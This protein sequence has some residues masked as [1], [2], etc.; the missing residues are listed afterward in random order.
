MSYNLK[1][2]IKMFEGL[3]KSNPLSKSP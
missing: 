1:D 3:D 2:G